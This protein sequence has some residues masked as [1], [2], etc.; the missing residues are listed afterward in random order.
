LVKHRVKCC[1]GQH[2]GRRIAHQLADVIGHF[3]R[4]PTELT[5]G[6]RQ[7]R[8]QRRPLLRIVTENRLVAPHRLF[9]KLN[10][11]CFLFFASSRLLASLRE[12]SFSF[13]ASHKDAKPRKDAKIIDQALLQLFSSYSASQLHPPQARLRSASDKRRKSGSTARERERA[14]ASAT[15]RSRYRTRLRRWRLRCS[16][17]LRRVVLG[18]RASPA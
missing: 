10:H 8:Q 9:A 13:S 5:L 3:L 6:K 15:R 4:D 2:V 1:D 11:P 16:R 14:T 7:H 12:T 18:C 17:T